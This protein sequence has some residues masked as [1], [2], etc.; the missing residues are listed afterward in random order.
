MINTIN[1]RKYISEISE[2]GLTAIYAKGY[3]KETPY[4]N[5]NYDNKD[6]KKSTYPDL[7]STVFW[8]AN[9]LTDKNGNASLEFFTADEATIYT[10][11]LTGVTNTGELIYNS[12]KISRK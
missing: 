4:P 12:T 8:K 3:S 2:N 5:P 10:V 6:V 1:K 7:R 11:T 9:F